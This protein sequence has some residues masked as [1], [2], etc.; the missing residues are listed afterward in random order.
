MRKLNKLF[1]AILLASASAI[2]TV[3]ATPSKIYED[4]PSDHW[5]YN[6]VKELKQKGWMIGLPDKT[7]AGNKPMSRYTFA[8]VV[9]RMLERYSEI[10]RVNETVIKGKKSMDAKDVKILEDLVSEFINEIETLSAE[11]KEIK[12]NVKEVEASVAEI[13]GNLTEI[14]DKNAEIEK[15][16][17]N[18]EKFDSKVKVYG[19]MLAQDLDYQRTAKNLNDF[20]NVKVRIGF[21]ANPSE[22]V[23]TDFQY[24]AYDKD[25]DSNSNNRGKT[26]GDGYGYDYNGTSKS[27]F[28]STRGSNEVEI[29]KI[30]V[31]N[32]MKNGDY[33]Q[34]GR[35]FMSHG[36]GLVINDYA[37]SVSYGTKLGDWSVRVNAI[38]ADYDNGYNEHKKDEK[39]WNVNADANISG[40][41]IYAGVYHQDTNAYYNVTR[42]TL[43]NITSST[44]MH[45]DRTKQVAELG[46]SGNIIKNGK[47]KY[48][49]G[50]VVSQNERKNVATNHNDKATGLMEHVA[51]TWQAEPKLRLKAT[52]TTADENFD[53]IISLDKN[54]GSV[55]GRQTPFDDIARFYNLLGGMMGDKFYNTSNLKLEFEY[56]FA[57]KQTIRLAYDMVKEN[58]DFAKSDYTIGGAKQNNWNITNQSGNSTDGLNK[59]DSKIT[60][61]EY[62]YHFDPS[63]RIS[64]GFTS[65]DNSNSRT[66]ANRKVKDEELFWTEL[67][68]KF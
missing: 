22:K 60:T 24:V 48:D 31:K 34:V 15:R 37:D 28:G 59:L 47:L 2:A 64:I 65:A 26:V 27:T 49:A 30:K 38:Y 9:N 58:D 19:D 57:N 40:H 62:K 50:A 67:Y 55:N 41:N 33:A 14:K 46:S 17:E 3:N 35:D 43:G 42:D 23:E 11:T 18:I 25:L 16:V 51:L 32:I 56:A 54:Q 53:G 10:Q 45:K 52:Y 61:L 21:K 5:A 68:S 20:Q 66:T 7:F 4:V 1:L 12:N 6:A 29:A 8:L 63:S 13:Q 36:H 44:L 39:I